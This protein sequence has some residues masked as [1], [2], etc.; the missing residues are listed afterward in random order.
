L[1]TG[2]NGITGAGKGGGAPGNPTPGGLLK[3]QAT[4][5]FNHPV[6]LLNAPSGFQFKVAEFNLHSSLIYLLRG[7]PAS[8]TNSLPVT[9]EASSEAKYNT[10]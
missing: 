4:R 6:P 8:I 1:D 9:K 5:V 2:P 10:P 7:G 3:E